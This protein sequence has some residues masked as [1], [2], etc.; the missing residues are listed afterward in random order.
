MLMK[1]K[2]SN[3]QVCK[4]LKF[5]FV[6]RSFRKELLQLKVNSAMSLIKH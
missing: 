4:L 2:C 5:G 6:N 3:F 1:N